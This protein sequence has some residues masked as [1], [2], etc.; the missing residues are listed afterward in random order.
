[1]SRKPVQVSIVVFPECDPSIIYGV[2]DTLWCAGMVW[3]SLNGLTRGERLFEPRL[4]A[5]EPGPMRLC[6]GVTIIPQATI[7]EVTRTDV[8]FVPNVMVSSVGDL[9]AL[10]RRMLDWIVRMH[11]KGTYLY[12]ACG[13]S[14]VL[15]EAGLLEGQQATTHW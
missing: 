10:D 8:V 1:M 12:A 11:A 15:A 2:F 7:A 6:T 4:V 14:L 13:G 3:D 9:Q 5:A